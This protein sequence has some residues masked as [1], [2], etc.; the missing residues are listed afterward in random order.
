MK[1]H[2]KQSTAILQ[3]LE[4]AIGH[5]PWN[6][7]NFLRIIGKNL[8]TIKDELASSL[9]ADHARSIKEGEPPPRPALQNGQQE[10]FVSLYTTEGNDLQSWE[11]ILTNLPKQIV[12]RAI[13]ANE[14]DVINLIKTKSQKSNE[15]YIAAYIEQNA[16]I[17]V[18]EDKIPKDK[19][20]V[21]LLVLKDRALS[22]DNIIKFIH[23]SG[24]YSFIKGRL[25]KQ[26][27][28]L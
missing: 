15:A 4:E 1:K 12:S 11:R 16:I 17:K 25:V 20:G 7:S 14:T 22:L 23:L 10:V 18:P 27:F 28:G 3:A 24:E 21:N 26:D 9:A 5:G 2:E 13:Y 6:E 19:F 8:R